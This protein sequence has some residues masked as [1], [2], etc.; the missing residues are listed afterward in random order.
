[1]GREDER[2]GADKKR[3]GERKVSGKRGREG[4][5]HAVEF[6]PTGDL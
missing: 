1:M 4:Q 6:F 2:G 5:S 3:K